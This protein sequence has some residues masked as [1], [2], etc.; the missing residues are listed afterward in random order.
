MPAMLP[1]EVQGALIP[2]PAGNR[3]WLPFHIC[4]EADCSQ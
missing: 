3:F 4:D 2:P 1:V